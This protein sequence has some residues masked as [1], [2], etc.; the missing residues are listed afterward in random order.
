MEQGEESPQGESTEMRKVSVENVSWTQAPH[1]EASEGPRGGKRVP[2]MI[3]T[4]PIQPGPRSY[5][6]GRGLRT[7]C[8]CG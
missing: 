2:S 3:L 6:Q 1:E 8:P 7:S 5:Q 4:R